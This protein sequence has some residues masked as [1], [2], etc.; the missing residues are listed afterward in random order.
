MLLGAVLVAAALGGTPVAA[1]PGD[2]LSECVAEAERAP[3]AALEAARAWEGRGGGDTARLCQ[4]LAL[5]YSGDFTQA[6]MQ[7]E[8]LAPTLGRA[9]S[10]DGEAGLWARAGWAWL[11]AGDPGRAGHAYSRALDLRPDDPELYIDRAFAHAEAGRY[12]AAAADLTVALA[13]APD[14]TDARLYR[15][16]AY[17]ELGQLDQAHANLAEVLRRMPEH[18][19]ALLQRGNLSARAGDLAAARSD[20]QRVLELDP[21]GSAGAAAAANLRRLAVPGASPPDPGFAGDRAR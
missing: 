2:T 5:F 12:D 8:A 17:Q 6:A 4:A 20:W 3:A 7:L 16:A 11:R 18:P 1:A 10:P 15:A 21:D 19:Q 13:R 14:R 9:R